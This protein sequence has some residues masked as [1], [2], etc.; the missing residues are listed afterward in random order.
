MNLSNYFLLDLKA[1]TKNG[2]SCT[3]QYYLSSKISHLL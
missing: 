1:V 3:L 2:N